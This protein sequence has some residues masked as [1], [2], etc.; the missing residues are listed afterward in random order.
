MLFSRAAFEITTA[1][2]NIEG[3]SEDDEAIGTYGCI[4]SDTLRDACALD[5]ILNFNAPPRSL[6]AIPAI[7]GS[8]VP[9]T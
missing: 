5:I 2:A 8:P 4:K 9:D 1:G 3:A 7:T 6:H